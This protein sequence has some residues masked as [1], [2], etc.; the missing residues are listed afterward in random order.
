MAQHTVSPLKRRLLR[1]LVR[2]NVELKENR[3]PRSLRRSTHRMRTAVRVLGLILVPVALLGSTRL[4][5]SLASAPPP[6]PRAAVA[7]TQPQTAARRFG[8]PMPINPDVL[9]LAVRKIALDPGH[10][11]GSLGTHTPQGLKEKDLTLDIAGRLR[12]L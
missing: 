11:G 9:P 1:E 2:D 6:A 7:Q 4:I 8:A 10:G 3:L 5:S 12:K